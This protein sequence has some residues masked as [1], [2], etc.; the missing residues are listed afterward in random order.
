LLLGKYIQLKTIRV[1]KNLFN[2][3]KILIKIIFLEN[4]P[5]VPSQKISR[6]QSNRKENES[7]DCSLSS[8][9]RIFNNIENE[10]ELDQM[11]QNDNCE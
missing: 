2:L 11:N 1:S 3:L 8:R 9:S 6:F 4:K 10:S 7:D 5:V